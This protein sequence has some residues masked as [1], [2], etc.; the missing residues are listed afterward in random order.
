MIKLRLRNFGPIID[1]G[2]LSISMVTMLIGPQSSGKSSVLKVLSLCSWLEKL[3]MTGCPKAHYDYTHY[4]RFVKELKNYYRLNDNYFSDNTEILYESDFILLR[5]IGHKRNATI[6][7]KNNSLSRRH[8][9][10]LS[11]IPSERNLVSA[12]KNVERTYRVS[13]FD[14]LYDFI[15]EWSKVRGKFTQT[16]PL[17]L[18]SIRNAT[19]YYDTKTGGDMIYLQDSGK[20]FSTFY[21]SSGLQ[22]ALPVEAL[23]T[24]KCSAIGT[25]APV[26]VEQCEAIEKMAATIARG[27]PETAKKITDNLQN[28]HAAKLFIEE[29]EQNLFPDSQWE[30][31]RKVTGLINSARSSSENN[32]SFAVLT[33]HSPY[34][35]NCLSILALASKAYGRNPEATAEI[36]DPALI[37]P[38][39]EINGWFINQGRMESIFD[40]DLSMLLGDRLDGVSDISEDL[41]SQLT[42][43]IY[44]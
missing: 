31:V 26:S 8:N 18:G 19:Y 11:F 23:L 2:D 43:I 27:N 35:L 25:Q 32:D 36:I 40:Q 30:L 28:Y 4:N 41:I 12:I 29:P 38:E 33:T 1:S 37:L 15:Y 16:S 39:G 34:V 3:I 44:G 21:A 9:S 10:A 42:D 24:Y 5:Q 22:S 7:I 6:A 20:T 14:V 17:R 13:D